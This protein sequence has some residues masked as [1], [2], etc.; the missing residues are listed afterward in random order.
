M[1]ASL[2]VVGRPARRLYAGQYQ[3]GHHISARMYNH[4]WNEMTP[5]KQQASAVS[6]PWVGRVRGVRWVYWRGVEMAVRAREA[7]R[8][9]RVM[10]RRLFGDPRPGTAAYKRVISEEIGAFSEIYCAAAETDPRLTEPVPAVWEKTQGLCV[11]RIRARTGM[12]VVGH[13]ASRLTERPGARLVSLGCGPGGVELAVAREAPDADYLCLDL[14]PDLLALGRERARSENFRF[15]FQ[16]AD[17]NTLSLPGG[18]FDVALCYASLH[19]LISLDH[20]LEQIRRCLRPGGALVV[21]DVCTPNGFHMRPDTRRA[22]RAIWETLPERYR[23]NHTAY[24]NPRL[25]TELWTGDTRRAG[26]ECV[27]SEDILP[28]LRRYFQE[29]A[30]VPLLSLATRFL[31]PMYGPNFD[32]EKPLDSSIATW[33][34]ELDCYLL[35]SGRLE[36]ESFF[37]VYTPR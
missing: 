15:T 29:S 11:E 24:A 9:L 31:N 30:F 22:A 25:D 17:L 13:V 20:V 26:M 16:E 6:I 12:D 27:R 18:E 34:W 14:N 7:R 33:I 36:P 32:L 3:H 10:R 1:R 23:L 8:W 19:H 21:M 5:R 4:P 28:L 2:Q 37:G 35:D